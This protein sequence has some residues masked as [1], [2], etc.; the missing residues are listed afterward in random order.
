[1][2]FAEKI[3]GDPELLIE[4]TKITLSIMLDIYNKLDRKQSQSY[5]NDQEL[6]NDLLNGYEFLHLFMKNLQNENYQDNVDLL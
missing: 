6:Q 5:E 4:M 3:D 2:F 1:M